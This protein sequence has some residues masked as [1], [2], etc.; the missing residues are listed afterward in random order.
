LGSRLICIDDPH[1]ILSQID[2]R[3]GKYSSSPNYS[4]YLSCWNR[5]IKDPIQNRM[6]Q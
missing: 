6:Y 4:W 5:Y 1:L 2:L 3:S